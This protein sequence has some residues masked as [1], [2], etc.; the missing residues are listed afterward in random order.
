[1]MGSMIFIKRPRAE[2][3]Q[4][5]YEVFIIYLGFCL[6]ALFGLGGHRLI[7]L[8][9][10][11]HE[12]DLASL[13]QFIEL[14]WMGAR[15]D[16]VILG[17]IGIPWLGICLAFGLLGV[18]SEKYPLWT[19]IYLLMTWLIAGVV[20]ALDLIFFALNDR[21]LQWPDHQRFSYFDGIGEFQKLLPTSMLVLGLATWVVIC[22]FVYK[23]TKALNQTETIRR[24]DE[25]FEKTG[26][27]WKMIWTSQIFRILVPLLTVAFFARGTLSAHHLELQHSEI[28]ELPVINEL[29]LNPLWTMDKDNSLR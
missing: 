15:F 25:F 3:T 28:S 17:F 27:P 23:S 18:W 14:F 29:V 16:L 9:I 13:W 12:L 2:I 5:V 10:S 7:N 19:K 11:Q 8:M 24:H 1:M 21:H 6:Y 4:R 26:V 22:I 20:G